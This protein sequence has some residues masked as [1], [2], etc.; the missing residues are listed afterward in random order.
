MISGTKV[1]VLNFVNTLIKNFS[2]GSAFTLKK[3]L[4]YKKMY[5]T[6]KVLIVQL[7]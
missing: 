4:F 5:I 3:I 1:G 6:C 7:I 2:L